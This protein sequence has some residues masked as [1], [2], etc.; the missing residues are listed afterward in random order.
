MIFLL[1]LLAQLAAASETTQPCS[2]AFD[3]LRQIRVTDSKAVLTQMAP[4][5]QCKITWTKGTPSFTDYA[6]IK[7]ELAALEAKDDAG[8]ALTAA[9][10]RRW[11]KII[12]KMF[13]LAR[14]P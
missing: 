14:R 10:E 13:S 12:L 4:P 3:I 7:D 1:V 6:A 5:D 8:K 11:R 9:E 2:H